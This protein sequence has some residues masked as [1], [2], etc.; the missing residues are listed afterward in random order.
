ME[1]T[2][3]R[4]LSRQVLTAS[5]TAYSADPAKSIGKFP[6]NAGRD[7]LLVSAVQVHRLLLLSVVV[8][9]L[10]AVAAAIAVSVDVNT[11]VDNF[12]CMFLLLLMLKLC[13]CYYRCFRLVV[14][15]GDA[16]GKVVLRILR[17]LRTLTLGFTVCTCTLHFLPAYRHSLEI[18]AT[19]NKRPTLAVHQASPSLSDPESPLPLRCKPSRQT[20]DSS[21]LVAISRSSINPRLYPPLGSQPRWCMAA[22]VEF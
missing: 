21:T 11:C 13:G 6:E 4:S 16:W 7:T 22:S 2:P 3:L 17:E 8:L 10:T 15:D 18:K 5:G 14:G 12:V 9:V 20:I 1:P 19:A